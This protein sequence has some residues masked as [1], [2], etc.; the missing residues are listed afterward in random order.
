MTKII[1]AFPACGKTYIYENQKDFGITVADSD[2]SGFSWIE[3]NG[4]KER[5]PD[6][7]NNYVEHIKS[8]LGKVDYIFVSSHDDVRDALDGNSLPYIFVKPDLN[9]RDEWIGRCWIR[10]NDEGFLT[11]IK[12][13]WHIWV[14]PNDNRLMCKDVAT[15]SSGE[16]LKDKLHWFETLSGV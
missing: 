6:F 14:L 13:N 10:G 1:S 16:Y 7:P 12:N 4:K 9:L 15:L 11:L 2:S 5:N 8:L 3:V